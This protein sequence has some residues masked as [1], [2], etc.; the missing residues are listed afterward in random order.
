ML[1]CV[2]RD[3]RDPY[4]VYAWSEANP[5]Q[6]RFGL[7]FG[8]F[9]LA[10]ALVVFAVPGQGVA[11]DR[12]AIGAIIVLTRQINQV[13]RERLTSGAVNAKIIPV[14]LPVAPVLI[15]FAFHAAAKMRS[16]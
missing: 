15:A 4:S 12:A 1:I 13:N 9:D 8:G 11:C 10:P 7:V 2:W 16:G 5:Q 6:R 14:R 3:V